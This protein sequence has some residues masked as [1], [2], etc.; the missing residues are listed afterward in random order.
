MH[1]PWQGGSAL[2]MGY[3]EK[4]HNPSP[5]LLQGCDG[6]AWRPGFDQ[7]WARIISGREEG[8][9]GWIA[10][11]YVTGHLAPHPLSAPKSTSVETD[12]DSAK[13]ALSK[14]QRSDMSQCRLLQNTACESRLRP[15]LLLSG[16]H[17]I[18]WGRGAP[19]SMSVCLATVC[20][21]C[22]RGVIIYIAICAG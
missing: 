9:Y 8:I 4:A 20:N 7:S 1:E 15:C 21:S 18:D 16:R 11:N 12:T 19:D 14:G 5:T 17:S 2:C 6:G 10:L 22:N 3:N 13:Q